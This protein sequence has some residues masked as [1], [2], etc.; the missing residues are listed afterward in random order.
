MGAAAD[1]P[2]AVIVLPEL[3]T[4]AAAVTDAREG[5]PSTIL[6]EHAKYVS[7]AATVLPVTE[8]AE[9]QD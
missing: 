5:G 4:T 6:A 7:T 2:V 9:L 1:V 3:P 8:P